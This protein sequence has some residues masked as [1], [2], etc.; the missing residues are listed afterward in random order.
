MLRIGQGFDI[1]RLEEG[2]PLILGGVRVPHTKGLVGH[3]DADVLIHAIIDSLIGAMGMGDIGVFFPDTDEQYKNADS[4]TL[5]RAI[6]SKAYTDYGYGL[7][8]LDTT[9]IIEKPKLRDYIDQMRQNLADDFAANIAQVNI[10]A[11]TSEAVGVVGH[12]EAVIAQ[13][14]ITLIK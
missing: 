12:E 11:K 6:I 5:L 10:K 1:H 2:Y 13:A 8:N 4:R 9:I 14:V 3:S 7:N